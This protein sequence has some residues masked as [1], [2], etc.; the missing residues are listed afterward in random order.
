[1]SPLPRM[2]FRRPLLRPRFCDRGQ[3]FKLIKNMK[4]QHGGF[5]LISVVIVLSVKKV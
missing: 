1:M 3:R 5:G 4:E 2:R